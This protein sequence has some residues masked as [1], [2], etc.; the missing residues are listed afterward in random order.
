MANWYAVG[1]N[2]PTQ[3]LTRDY[4]SMF[5][6]EY[7]T[8]WVGTVRNQ[9]RVVVTFK[10]VVMFHNLIIVT[11]SG[12]KNGFGNSY[13]SMCLVLDDD[14]DGKICTSADYDVD[15]GQNIL[16]APTNPIWA[17]KVELL[18]QKDQAAQIADFKIHYQGNI[19]TVLTPSKEP[20]KL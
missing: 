16:L 6:N 14:S 8:L 15:A 19:T 20:D 13:K 4:L 1:G 5:D 17:T 2:T 18:V 11:S 7:S 9:K 3:T 12:S 10:E